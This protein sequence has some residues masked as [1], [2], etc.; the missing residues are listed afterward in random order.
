VHVCGEDEVPSIRDAYERLWADR[1]NAESW[2]ITREQPAASAAIR[3]V[4]R[5]FVLLCRRLKLFAV[6]VVTIDCSQFKAVS[7]R[8][9][10]LS[11]RNGACRPLLVGSLLPH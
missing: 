8:D 2:A 11:N 3:N 4:C 10:D 6:G 5:E 1:S 7:A 9:K